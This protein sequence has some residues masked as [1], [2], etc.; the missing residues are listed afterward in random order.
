MT[1]TRAEKGRSE[2][3]FFTIWVLG[4]C[5]CLFMI[6]GISL[7]LWRGFS[8]R[9]QLAAMTDAAAVAAASQI[10]LT[11]FRSQPSRLE[12]NQEDARKRATDYMTAEATASNLQLTGL[13]VKVNGPVVQV[14]AKKKLDMTLTRILVPNKD[15]DVSTT[16]AAEARLG[17]Q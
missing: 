8:D 6:G 12:L 13:E 14:I 4:L 15:I 1:K 11:A 2:K 3:G 7:D 9:R 16:S 5:M 10:D 17:G